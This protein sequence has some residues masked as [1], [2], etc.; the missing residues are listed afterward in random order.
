VGIDAGE[1]TAPLVTLLRPYQVGTLIGAV[2]FAC[3]VTGTIAV[4]QGRTPLEPTRV[5]RFSAQA[6]QVAR[7]DATGV[8]SMP[9][10]AAW[11]RE[12]ALACTT[13]KASYDPCFVTAREDVVICVSDPRSASGRV[14]LKLGAAPVRRTDPASPAHQAWFIEL[15]DGTTCRPLLSPGREVEGLLELYGCTFG[16]DGPADAVLGDLDSTG[17]VWSISKVKINKTLLM[18]IKWT[19]SAPVKTVWQ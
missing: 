9:S 1:V 16:I 5:V 3:D 7:A 6:E 14:A 13:E 12:D 15:V 11:F 17:S 8:C 2:L 19:A 4:S 10:R 18:T